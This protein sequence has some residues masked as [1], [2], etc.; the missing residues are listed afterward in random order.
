MHGDVRFQSADGTRL[1]GTLA[2]PDTCR[3]AVLFLHGITGDRRETG[4]FGPLARRL[5]ERGS[6]SLR[7]DFRGHG[8]SDGRPEDLTLSGCINDARAGLRLLG[9]RTGADRFDL[10][11]SSFGGGI[12][13]GL[14]AL[15]PRVERLV[16]IAPR[17]DYRLWIVNEDYWEGQRLTDDAA[18]ALREDGFLLRGDFRFGPAM[19]NEL[20]TFDGIAA[21]RKAERPTLILHGDRDMVVEIDLSRDLAR[22]LSHVRLT[23]YPNATHGLADSDAP[24]P[25]AQATRS[26]RRRCFTEILAFLHRN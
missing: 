4:L 18:H 6:A 7:F 9:E 8:V 11:A 23:E 15:E 13:A 12:A 1:E 10:I 26:L 24:T 20:L 14:A 16:L 19:A 21:L 22:S 2:G 5:A 25:G 3:R 17:L